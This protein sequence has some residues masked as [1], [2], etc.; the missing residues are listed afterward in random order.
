[1]QSR[2]LQVVT[3]RHRAD[4][5]HVAD[6]LDGRRDGDG[7]HEQNGGKFEGRRSEAWQRQPLSGMHRREIDHSH[8]QPQHIP[9]QDTAED[10]HQ[11]QHATPE[12]RQHQRHAKTGQ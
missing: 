11:T 5:H 3:P 4:R 7:N 10:R 8:H 12:D 6:M 1:M 9:R 2:L